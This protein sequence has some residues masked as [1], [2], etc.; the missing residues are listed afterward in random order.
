MTDNKINIGRDD[1][2]NKF[3][4]I[5]SLAHRGKNLIEIMDRNKIV[6]V[7]NQIRKDLQD[8]EVVFGRRING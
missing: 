5:E 6:M 8:L 2:I 7:M 3:L 1:L 4:N